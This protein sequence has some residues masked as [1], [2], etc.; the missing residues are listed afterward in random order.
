MRRSN[1]AKGMAKLM[2]RLMVLCLIAFCFTGRVMA[3]GNDKRVVIKK[4]ISVSGNTTTHYLA[5]VKNG[6]TGEWELQDATTFG[7]ECLWYTGSNYNRA[8]TDHNYYFIDDQSKPRFLSAPLQSGGALTLTANKPATYLL[9]NTD[10]NY[11]FYDWDGVGLARGHKNAPITSSAECTSVIGDWNADDG[12]C[13]SVYWVEYDLSSSTWKMTDDH[14]YSITA[15][16][17]RAYDVTVTEHTAT[18]ATT[19]GGLTGLTLA[20]EITSSNSPLTPTATISALTYTNLVPAHTTYTYSEITAEKPNPSGSFTYAERTIYYYNS[21]YSTTAPTASASGS[22][23]ATSYEWKLTGDGAEFLS[24]A[25]GSDVTTATSTP[26]E[27]RIYYRIPNTTG[28]KTATLTLTVTFG[29]GT[30]AYTMT[31]TAD[32]VVKTTCQNPAKVA[33]PQVSFNDVTVSWYNTNATKYKVEWTL[34]SDASW[35]SSQVQEVEGATSYTITGLEYGATYKYRVYAYC[36][37]SYLSDPTSYTFTIGNVEAGL[38]IYGSIFGGGRMADV[39]GKTEVII[40]NCDTL[41]AVYGGNDIAGSVLGADGSLIT[42][43]VNSSDAHGY[44]SYGT[45]SAN[46]KIGSVYGGGNGYYAYNGS[47]FAAADNDHTSQSVA[48][49]GSVNAMTQQHTV[50]AAAWTNTGSDPVTLTIPAIVK[51]DITVTNNYVKVDSLFGGAKNAFLTLDDGTKNGSTITV[52]G[53]TVYALFGGNNFGGTQ[54]SAKHHI[55]VIGTKTYLEPNVNNNSANSYGRTFGIRYLFGGG[56]K[57]AGSTTEIAVTGGQVDTLFGGGNNADVAAAN[58][59]VNCSIASGSDK[60]W[61]NTYSNAISSCDGS[62]ITPKNDYTWNGTGVYNVRTLFGGNNAANMAGLPTITLTSGSVGTVYGGGNAGDMLAHIADAGGTDGLI[63]D[64]FGS[65]M[66]GPTRQ[67]IYY[68]THV[69]MDSPKILVDYLYGGCQMSNVEYSTWVEIKDGHVG[70]VYGGCNISGDVGSNY[71]IGYSGGMTGEEYQYVK[72]ATYVKASGGNVYGNIFAGSNGLYH[73]NDAVYYVSGIDYDDE[74][75][76][77]IGLEIPTHNETHVMVSGDVDIKENVYAGGNM[78]PVGFINESARGYTYRT[79]VGF[80]SIRMD[81]GT[82]HGS[83]YGGGNMASIFGSNEVQVSGGTINGALYGGNDRAGQVAQISN[84]ALPSTYDIASDGKTSLTALAVNTYVSLTGK[85]NVNTVY[86]GGNGAYT[87]TAAEFCDVTDQ[88][89]QTNTFV[90]INIDGFETSLGAHDGGQIETVY[91]GGNGVTVTGGITVLL[92]VKGYNGADPDAYDHVGTIFGGNNMGDLAIVPDIVLLNGQVN[93]VYGG[94]NQGA[95]VGGKTVTAVNGDTYTNVGS[96]VHLRSTYTGAGS[97][98]AQTVK[99]TVSGNVYGGCRMNG[100]DHNSLVLI[101]GGTHSCGIFGGSD[102][103]GTISGTS[104]VAVYA[105]SNVRSNIYGGGNGNYDYTSGPYNGMTAPI[106]NESHVYLMGGQV[107]TSEAHASVFGGGF[108]AATTT[109]GNVTV[110]VGDLAG[111]YTPTIY[112]DIYGG[113]ALGSVNDQATDITTVEF[114]NGTLTGNIFGGGMGDAGD[115]TMGKV[116]GKI[117]VNIG[118]ELQDDANCHIDLRNASVYGCNNT[119][120]SPQA[121]VEVHIWKTG[122]TTTDAATYLVSDGVNGNPTY[123]IA[124]VFGGGKNANYLPENG[125]SSSEKR[126]TV[127]IHGCNN[128]VANVYAGGDAAA[129]TGVG[130]TIDG[131]RFDYVFGGGNGSVS[132]ANIGSGGTLT[133]VNA[134]VINHLFGGSNTLGTITGTMNT[135]VNNSGSCPED[136]KEFFA[137]GNLAVI[138]E[139]G[140]PVDMSTT[141]GCGTIFG[142]IYGGSNLADIYGNVTLTVNGGTIDYVYGG[143]KGRV[144]DNSDPMNPIAAKAADIHGNVTLNIY[145]GD[146]GNAFGGSNINGNITGRIDVELDWASPNPCSESQQLDNLY[147]ASNLATYTP[148][149]SNAIGDN[150]SPLVT[151]KHGVVGRNVARTGFPRFD[152]TDFGEHG[153]VF[154]GGKGDIADVNAGK[155]TANPK[156]YLNANSANDLNVVVMNAVYGGGAL[157]TIDGNTLV[158]IDHGHVGCA[159][160]SSD[161]DNTNSVADNLEHDNGFVFGAGKGHSSNPQLATVLGNSNV[162]M[163]GGYVHNTLFGG[164]QLASVGTFNR[165]AANVPFIQSAF[166]PDADSIVIGEPVECTAGG[167]ATVSITGGQV[168]PANVTMKADKGYVFGASQGVY[169][170]PH[171]AYT[172]PFFNNRT[173]GY[174]NARFGYVDSAQVNVSSNAFIVGAVW[175]GSENGQVLSSCGVHVSGGQIGVGKNQ[176]GAYSAANWTTAEAAV[177]ETN[178]AAATTAINAIAA[179]MPECESWD[180]AEQFEPYDTY[181]AE[182]TS[183]PGIASNPGHDGHTFFGNVFGGGSGY[184]PYRITEN[185]VTSSVW[186]EFQGRVRGNSWVVITGG[187]VLTSVYGGCEYADVLGDSYVIMSNGTVGTPRTVA[188]IEAHPVVCNVYGAGKGDQRTDFN[189]RTNVKNAHVK[190]SGGTVFGT[191]F[192]GGEDGHILNDSY[193]TISDNAWIGTWGTTTFDGNVFG[194]GRGFGGTALTAGSIGGN[195]TVNISGTSTVLG[196]VYG[197]GRLASVGTHFV[198]PD[199]PRYG[200]LVGDYRGGDTYH[201]N[202]LPADNSSSATLN[203]HGNIVIN[204]SGGTIGNIHEYATLQEHTIG[205]NVFG[206]SMGRVLM[207]GRSNYDDYRN[208]NHLWPGLAKCRSTIVTISGTALVKSNVYGGGE[209]GYVMNDSRVVIEGGTVGTKITPAVG[210]HYQYIGSVFGGG[211]GSDNITA[212]YNDS[213]SVDGYVTAT[214]HAGRVYGNASVEMSAGHV[215]G[216]VYG[217]GEL[218]SVGRRWINITSD[219]SSIEP[220]VGAS[221]NTYTTSAVNGLEFTYNDGVHTYTSDPYNVPAQTYTY[222][223]LNNSVG[224]ASVAI[225]G[226]IIGEVNDTIPGTNRYAGQPTGHMGFVFG[227]SKGRPGLVYNGTDYGLHHTRMAYVDSAKVTVS[228]SAMIAAS[229]FGGGENGHVRY[230]TGVYVSGGTVGLRLSD[231]FVSAVPAEQRDSIEHREVDGQGI[232]IYFGNVYGGGRGIDAVQVRDGGQDKYTYSLSS[233]RVYGNTTVEISGGH[234]THNV[235]GG[236]SL[237]SVGITEINSTGTARVTITGGVVGFDDGHTTI[238]DVTGE[239][240]YDGVAYD[241]SQPNAAAQVAVREYYLRAGI[242]GGRVYGSGRG[243]AVKPG[244][245]ADY[246]R[247]A[248]VKNSYV[249]IGDG[250]GTTNKAYVHGSVFGGGANGHVRQDTHVKIRKGAI[251]GLPIM[252]LDEWGLKRWLQTETDGYISHDTMIELASSTRTL[253]KE[254]YDSEKEGGTNAT[255]NGAHLH[256]HW[257]AD[258]GTGPTVYRGNVYGGG[259]GITPT[260]NAGQ[261]AD[262]RHYSA[263]AG[264]VYRNVYLTIDGGRIFHNVYGGGS[265]ASVGNAVDSIYT[266]DKVWFQAADGAGIMRITSANKTAANRNDGDMISMMGYRFANY[267]ARLDA[268]QTP[269]GTLYYLDGTSESGDARYHYLKANAN[270]QNTEW[271]DDAHVYLPGDPISNTGTV[272]VTVNGGIIGTDGINDGQLFGSGRGIAG[273]ITSDVSHLANATNTVIYIH[274]V[275][276]I[277]NANTATGTDGANIR[278]AVFGGGANGH[279]IQNTQVYMTGGTVGVPLP[280]SERK[281]DEA[282]GHGYRIYR[283]NIYGGGRGVDPFENGTHLSTTAGRVY[284]NTRVEVSGGTVYHAVYGGGSLASVG[285][286]ALRTVDGDTRHFYIQGTGQA[287]VTVKGDA[288]IGHPWRDVELVNADGTNKAVS[289]QDAYSAQKLLHIIGQD[290][291]TPWGSLNDAQKRQYVIE[292]NYHFLGSNSGMVFGSGRGVGALHNGTIDHDYSEAAFTRNTIVNVENSDNKIPIVCGSVFGGGEN[293]HV[294]HHTLVQING[295]VIGAIP[296]HDDHFITNDV[297]HY[298]IGLSGYSSY[299]YSQNPTA[300][301]LSNLNFEDSENNAGHGPAVYRGNVYGG[302]RGVD[303]TDSQAPE[304]GYSATAGRVYGNVDVNILGG[305][306]YHHVFGGGSLASVGTYETDVNNLPTEALGLYEYQQVRYN[307]GATR[308]DDRVNGNYCNMRSDN[309]AIINGF[310]PDTMY[311]EVADPITGSVTTGDIEVNVFGGQV[312]RFGINEGSVFGGGRGIAGSGSDEVTHMAYANNT[313]VNIFGASGTDTENTHDGTSGADIRGSVFGGGANGHVLQDARVVMTGGNVGATLSDDDKLVNEYGESVRGDTLYVVYHGNVYGGGRGVDPIQSTS[314]SQ[315]NFSYTAGRV[316]GN[317]YVTINGGTVQRNVY[318]GGSLATV[319][320]VKYAVDAT[321]LANEEYTSIVPVLKDPAHPENGYWDHTGKLDPTTGATT[322][323]IGGSAVI[324]TDGMNNGRVFGS[325]RGMAGV[326]YSDRAYVYKSTVTVGCNYDSGTDTYSKDETCTAVVNGCV[327]GSGENGHVDFGG[328][329]VIIG[330]GTIGQDVSSIF[331]AIDGNGSLT[332]EQ[333]AAEKKKYDYIGNVYGGGRGVDF[334][335]NENNGVNERWNSY[336]AGYVRGNTEVN[337]L[338]GTIHRNVYGGGSMGLVGDYG[339]LGQEETFQGTLGSNG[340]ATVNILSSVGSSAHPDYGGN[341]FGSS[342]GRANDPTTATVSKGAYDPDNPFTADGYFAEMAYV[343]QTIVNVGKADGGAPSDLTVWGNVYG[344]GENGHVDYGGTEVNILSGTIKKNV[345]G[346]GAGSTSSPTAGIVDGNTQVNI[347][348]ST[349]YGEATING[350]VF[351]GNDTYSSPLGIMRVDIWKTYRSGNTVFPTSLLGPPIDTATINAQAPQSQYYALAAVYGGGNKANVLTGDV[352]T[353]AYDH[354]T[355]NVFDDLYSSRILDA[356]WNSANGGTPRKSVVYVHGCEN[357]IMYVYGGGNAAN[358]IQNDV[359]IEGGRFYQVFAGGNGAGVGNPGANVGMSDESLILG[360]T[361]TSS[362]HATDKGDASI[363]IEGGIIDQAFGGSN[364]LGMIYGVST[365]NI[366]EDAT[367][368]RVIREVYGGGN[369]ADGGD[370]VINLPCMEASTYIPIFFAGANNANIGSPSLQKNVVLNVNGGHYGKIFGGNNTGGTIYGN[371]TVNIF[372]G[373][374]HEVFGGSNLGGDIKGQI[375]VNID[376]TGTGCPLNLDYVYGGGNEVAYA[377]TFSG[378]ADVSPEVNVLQGTVNQTVFGGGKGTTEP[379]HEARVT[380]RPTVNIGDDQNLHVL[381]GN[382]SAGEL[383]GM[384][385]GGGNIAPV[386]GSTQVVVRGSN[387]KVWRNVYGGGNGTTAV[388]SANTDVTIGALPE[389]H[390]PTAVGALVATVDQNARTVKLTTETQGAVIRYTLDGENPL[391]YAGHLGYGEPVSVTGGSTLRA[392]ATRPGYTTTSEYT[393]TSVNTP[394]ISMGATTA[395]VTCATDGSTIYYTTDGS[396]PTN[397]SSVYS[398]AI[399]PTAGQPIRVMAA[400]SSLVNSAEATVEAVATPVISVDGSGNVTITC[401]TEGA[402]I[403]YTTNGSTPT[404]SSSSYST[405]ITPGAGT[406]VKAI[407]VKSGLVSSATASETL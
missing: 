105:P 404:T 316:Y 179:L 252:S 3:Q 378:V 278:G 381:V 226:G 104:Q 355:S 17:A 16:A 242:N 74:E 52:K 215:L 51:T 183:D 199:D 34:N 37:S 208:F 245:L 119:N 177:R 70:T 161:D 106:S 26:A 313:F 274:G 167:I 5:H 254:Y 100:V 145:G 110:T 271:E 72:G 372:G 191:V 393:I 329:K 103:S 307:S 29:T 229:V 58:I 272:T 96:L 154:G 220:Y 341:V 137:G 101:E 196:S 170:Q 44:D 384:V 268:G 127:H 359:T 184:Y 363:T 188:Q 41:G 186:Y 160:T 376:S 231:H 389:G 57:V 368:P 93:T 181:L 169:T 265:L 40:I 300:I 76:Y 165:A 232:E 237:A 77:Y 267:P 63:A 66:L 257:E 301:T 146:I 400:K 345:F 172:D 190:V 303:H 214:M 305:V 281:V 328:T 84:R 102:I 277:D 6:S 388:V 205:G 308:T 38:V 152:Y 158:Q 126:T 323:N 325:C 297:N 207:I 358:T 86:G 217:G 251:I 71:M 224:V 49:S 386:T 189:M 47:S 83:V 240:K 339:P 22:V 62:T 333:K 398:S 279:V 14:S 312:G 394:V 12:E 236:G 299:R 285:S 264:R 45:T 73:C 124:N 115:A 75:H 64:D 9:S 273:A 56:N 401:A 255:F 174:A 222:Y 218:A 122:H 375:I 150:F 28:D 53:G 204:I 109:T 364:T 238:D 95:M 319:G 230:G 275:N 23:A 36:G 133:V 182:G 168:G 33:D 140:H 176:S 171:V 32:V 213:I 82:V 132:A 390:V 151:L 283:G 13:W 15:N 94:C 336:S 61:D 302:G 248:Y 233:G 21:A 97:N 89:I 332:D 164:G 211:Y 200:N 280:L 369:R 289:A 324:G 125:S 67:Q 377:P 11:Y 10:Q 227:G 348:T 350:S 343:F 134:G 65:P 387:T 141:I 111:S 198:A 310:E 225:S 342:R 201:G 306:I 203:A 352:A 209:L 344:G 120:G 338:G 55:D 405:T 30:S 129:A 175:G 193:V 354:N 197:G 88:P 144:A 159:H 247:M 128:T 187:H 116:N 81:G 335:I 85:P 114:L 266:A 287:S 43:G 366:T 35:A 180:Y 206:A 298:N 370:I 39:T 304:S 210:A 130:L 54:K 1:R 402:T 311:V 399:T 69:V 403:Y 59:T 327:F 346:G 371:V 42:L 406:T 219:P 212:H 351:G 385:F 202:L 162:V 87:Y 25:S 78:A 91:G 330:G 98:V 379:G 136:I 135:T 269:G 241:K 139:V 360:T 357:T 46:L 290:P 173:L 90:D 294:K 18:A 117:F 185:E 395:T 148:S 258:N 68:S 216:N 60:T 149:E 243:H 142:E 50:G 79:F 155:V 107:G 356:D 163:N 195:A 99:A 334:F 320:T 293:G 246:R 314:G 166:H 153:Q 256:E 223:P 143:S 383:M 321:A 407:A 391:N 276:G 373:D 8:G 365:V 322:V 374:I 192:G 259:R 382:G 2:Q 396:T 113:S 270:G 361:A 121:D 157:A 347:G 228:G 178:S 295:G 353:D 253:S 318:G 284:G 80:A 194:G 349:T 27:T 392:V 138:G 234:V 296:L 261:S 92:N 331:T 235:Y 112:G 262:L 291:S 380:A 367:C 309:S 108:G 48:V 263:T 147:G 7:P 239:F 292:L 131:G 249:T 288:V 250:T 362:P 4:N 286:Y 221:S 31:Q 24:F 19:S 397:S 244:D 282:T 340:I 20:S 123:A 315:T 337:I 156:V 326:D 260:G 118:A 317:S